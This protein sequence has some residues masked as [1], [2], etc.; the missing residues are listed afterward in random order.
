MSL[1]V[2]LTMSNTVPR[3][4][5]GIFIRE[6][7]ATKE[8][9]VEEWNERFPERVPVVM[10]DRD[11]T[12]EV[13]SANITHN[14]NTMAEAAGVY[15]HLWRPDEVG[16]TKAAQLF[17][18]LREGL[19]RLKANPSRFEALNPDNGWGDYSSLVEF[20]SGY[21]AACEMWPEADVR[22]SR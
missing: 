5:S 21:L 9:S 11:E 7:G 17:T 13:Y 2:Y 15:K 22:V 4:G 19:K 1:D 10:V 6:N 12:N 14:L 18:P 20:V 8:V 3:T 16:I